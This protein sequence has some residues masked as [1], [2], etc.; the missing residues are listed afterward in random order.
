M[1]CNLILRGYLGIPTR[2]SFLSVVQAE[3]K[4]QQKLKLV[5]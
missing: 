5:L 4:L 2:E 1:S 3:E